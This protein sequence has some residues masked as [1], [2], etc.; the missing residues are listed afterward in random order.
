MRGELV[1]SLGSGLVL[2]AVVEPAPVEAALPA[3]GVVSSSTTASGL[4]TMAV[5]IPAHG[6]DEYNRL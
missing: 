5:V 4:G 1:F 2:L 3:L 6:K